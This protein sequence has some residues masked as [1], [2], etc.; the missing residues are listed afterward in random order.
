MRPLL[1]GRVSRVVPLGLFILAV[2]C[3]GDS[4]NP[5]PPTAIHPAMGPVGG[6]S[7]K[8]CRADR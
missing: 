5:N 8:S 7:P 2:S 4:N 6:G 1:A 3:G